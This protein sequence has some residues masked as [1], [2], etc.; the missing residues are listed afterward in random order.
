MASTPDSA[1][2]HFVSGMIRFVGGTRLR[3]LAVIVL[4]AALA[5]SL[6]G[7]FGTHAVPWPRRTLFWLLL[8]GSNLAKWELLIALMRRRGFGYLGITLAGTMLMLVSIPIEVSAAL[9]L[10]TD[11]TPAPPGKTFLRVAALTLCALIVLIALAPRLIKPQPAPAV[12]SQGDIPRYPG[13]AVR[14]S[15]IAAIVSE[16]HYIR[17]Y[18]VGGGDKL[19]LGRLRDAVARMEGIAGA[20]VHRGAWVA[21]AHR[22]PARR[23]GNRWFLTAGAELELPVSR[24]LA[25]SLRLRGWLSR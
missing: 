19:V 10:L 23:A 8:L 7:A 22:G 1:N 18:L 12:P 20:Q 25:P 15:E 13:T 21:D 14:L 9:R 2:P 3:L 17:L 24:R 5:A 6:A 4:T 11:L 16:D